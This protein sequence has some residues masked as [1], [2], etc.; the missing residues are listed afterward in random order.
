MKWVVLA[1]S[2][3]LGAAVL[4]AG[5]AQAAGCVKGAVVGGAAGH[6]MGHHGVLGAMAGCAIGHH[7]AEKRAHNAQQTQQ[8]GYGSSQAPQQAPSQH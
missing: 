5:P 3:A 4:P 1:A 7:R 2:M 8:A 6:F